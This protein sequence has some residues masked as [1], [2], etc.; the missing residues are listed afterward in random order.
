VI[1]I[2]TVADYGESLDEYSMYGYV[3]YA[4]KGYRFARSPAELA[5]YRPDNLIRSSYY[6]AGGLANRLLQKIVP[7]WTA[8]TAWHLVYFLT[9]LGG[10]WALYLLAA[11]WLSS[12]SAFAVTLLYISQPLFWGHAFI[13]PK[14]IPFTALFIASVYTGF[15]MSDKLRSS[16][17]MDSRVLPAALLLGLTSSIRVAGPLAGMIVIAHA[18][19]RLRTRSMLL[20]GTYVAIAGL[21]TYLSWPLLWHGPFSHYAATVD[22]MLNFGWSESVLFGGHLY[23]GTDLPR[24]YLP[25]LVVIQLTEPLLLLGAA[26]LLLCVLDMIRGQHQPPLALFL[27]WTVAPA[28]A[29]IGLQSTLYD[30]ARQ[31]HF[32]L[33]PIF[34]LAGVA[35]ERIL[36]WIGRPPVTGAVILIA[37][38]P[39]ILAAVQLHPYEYVYYNGLVGGTRGAYGR[40]EMDYW[41]TSFRELITHINA[42]AHDRVN[43]LIYGPP[44]VT[45]RYGGDQL[46][47][48]KA[49][50]YGPGRQD[51]VAILIRGSW[52][53]RLCASAPIDFQVGRL[54]ATF[55][56]IRV[57]VDGKAC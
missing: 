10:A 44:E 49:P 11:R 17:W 4:L 21:T 39:G 8:V 6:I 7:A 22:V 15:R 20:V 57:P 52:N 19:H 27:I 56:L 53:E 13:N 48:Y 50:Y 36:A 34:I 43:V 28:L 12:I 30:N 41:G 24:A 35:L 26:G 14:D 2:V 3:D 1:G 37:A 55:G 33:P 5:D 45:A 47:I 54:G 9:F 16:P 42:E 31:A 38:L 18:I 23:P 29:I 40:Y 46:T 51:Y 32:L 25:M